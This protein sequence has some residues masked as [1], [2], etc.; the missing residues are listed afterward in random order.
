MRVN[1]TAFTTHEPLNVRGNND[2]WPAS[3]K[4]CADVG[5]PNAATLTTPKLMED[6]LRLNIDIAGAWNKDG[7]VL[8]IS[9]REK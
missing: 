6:A 7:Q 8:T 9:H 1:V 2:L 5:S 3:S 4:Q